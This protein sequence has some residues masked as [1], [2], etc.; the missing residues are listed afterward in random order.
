[1]LRQVREGV[2][3]MI[4]EQYYSIVNTILQYSKYYKNSNQHATLN[5]QILKHDKKRSALSG[6]LILYDWIY[7]SVLKVY[8]KIILW[9]QV[10][11]GGMHKDS[12]PFFSPEIP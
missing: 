6:R 3:A 7:P 10:E 8:L 5:P 9:L 4:E 11:Y 2:E 1:M 12:F